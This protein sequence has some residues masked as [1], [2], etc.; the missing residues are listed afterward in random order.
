[1]VFVSIVLMCTIKINVKTFSLCKKLCPQ[2]LSL[3][4]LI[5]WEGGEEGG[6]VGGEGEEKY[7]L[8]S[9]SLCKSPCNPG[10]RSLSGGRQSRRVNLRQFFGGTVWQK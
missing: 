6:K 2:V 9:R 8:Y 10:V 7:F 1:M 5:C 3:Q 4:P